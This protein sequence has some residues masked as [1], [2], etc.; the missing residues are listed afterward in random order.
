MALKELISMRKEFMGKA[1]KLSKVSLNSISAAE[2]LIK[3]VKM[4]KR[5]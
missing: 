4:S 2:F 3:K 1:I 5:N